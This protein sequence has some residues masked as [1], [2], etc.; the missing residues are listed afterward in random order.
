MANQLELLQA[1]NESL[2]EKLAETE[3]D[4]KQ[5]A[6]TLLSTLKTIGLDPTDLVAGGNPM[7]KIAKVVPNLI[8]ESQIDPTYI[9]RTFADLSNPKLLDTPF[10]DGSPYQ[11]AFIANLARMTDL[12][13]NTRLRGVG[14]DNLFEP[15]G[16]NAERSFNTLEAETRNMLAA[17]N[18]AAQQSITLVSDASIT[19]LS[20]SFSPLAN[21]AL[22]L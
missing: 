6:S 11:A 16:G 12:K 8:L 10:D 2:H 7:K 13:Q 4:I 20:S 19:I 17:A 21:V 3:S 18:E 15:I 1:E 9:D 14:R 5:V 22:T